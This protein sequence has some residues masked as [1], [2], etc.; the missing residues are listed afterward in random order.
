MKDMSVEELEYGMKLVIESDAVDLIGKMAIT[1]TWNEL[2]RRFEELE[3]SNKELRHRLDNSWKRE[4]KINNDV[5][6]LSLENNNLRCCGN[7]DLGYTLQCPMWKK[8]KENRDGDYPAECGYCSNWTTDGLTREE[9]E[10]K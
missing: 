6:N 5:L 2:L 10:G 7:C 8:Y 9:R 4:D 3:N 1:N